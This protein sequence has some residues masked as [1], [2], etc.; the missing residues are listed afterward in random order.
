MDFNGAKLI[1]AKDF[2]DI[3]KRSKVDPN[4][5]LMA[6]I[7]TIGNPVIVSTTEPFAIKNVA[8][9]K[10]YSRHLYDENFLYYFLLAASLKMKSLARGGLQPFVSLGFLRNYPIAL[11]PLKEQKQISKQLYQLLSLINQLKDKKRKEDAIKADLLKILV[12]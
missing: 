6:M 10:P 8:L 2:N 1:S 12:A 5:V 9:F 7:G 11:P 4:D 3:N